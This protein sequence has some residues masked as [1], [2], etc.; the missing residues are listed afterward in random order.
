[1]QRIYPAS[2]V[3][4]TVGTAVQCWTETATPVRDPTKICLPLDPYDW[5]GKP[6][7]CAKLSTNPNQAGDIHECLTGIQSE[8]LWR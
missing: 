4:S 7:D 1:M 8:N 5:T 2:A 6:L 3:K